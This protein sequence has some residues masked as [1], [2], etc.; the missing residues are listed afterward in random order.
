MK[1][2]TERANFR[3]IDAELAAMQV[4]VPDLNIDDPIEARRIDRIISDE[5]HSGIDVSDVVVTDRSV[6]RTDGTQIGVRLYQAADI[7]PG[8]HPVLIFLHGGCFVLGGLYSEDARCV[9]YARETQSIVIAVDY[10]L[11]PEFPFPAGLEDCKAVLD[12][13]RSSATA[14]AFDLNRIAIGGISAGGALSA[15]VALSD[16]ASTPLC[17]LMLL[18]SVVDGRANTSSIADFLINPVLNSTTVM[19]MWRA[20]LGQDWTPGREDLPPLASPAHAEIVANLPTTFI[21]AA[22]L[23]PLRDEAMAFA[24]RLT[25]EGVPVTFRFY[26]KAFHSFDSFT[27]T[28]LARQA[29]GHQVA[30]INEAFV[31]SPI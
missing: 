20:Y 21:A 23:D 1:A 12:W 25:R 13:T 31:L 18:Y 9:A 5:M 2:A 16:T 19:K 30:A 3:A 8:P 14:E 10:R 24:E 11:A 27:A 4:L 7:G 17:L 22:E 29:V 26:P 28:R 6:N 15:A